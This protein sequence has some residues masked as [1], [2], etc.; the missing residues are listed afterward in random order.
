MGNV[1]N[2]EVV[3]AQVLFTSDNTSH[4]LKVIIVPSPNFCQSQPGNLTLFTNQVINFEIDNL[5]NYSSGLF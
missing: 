5:A 3:M 1:W 4:P 2:T